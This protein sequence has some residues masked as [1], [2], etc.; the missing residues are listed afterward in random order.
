MT[1]ANGSVTPESSSA[2]RSA[3]KPS[4]LLIRSRSGASGAASAGSDWAACTASVMV[5]GLQLLYG[6]DQLA[7]GLDLGLHV[8]RDED[9]EL[10]L[11]RGD[12]IHHRQ[13]VPLEVA[14]EGGRLAQ[15]HALLVEGLD[16]LGNFVEGL[17]AVAHL[18]AFVIGSAAASAGQMRRHFVRPI[19]RNGRDTTPPSRRGLRPSVLA[20]ATKPHRVVCRH[21][22]PSRDDRNRRPGPPSAWP[23]CRAPAGRRAPPATAAGG[24]GRSAAPICRAHRPPPARSRHGSIR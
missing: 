3:I 16:Q 23:A 17:L 18:T 12:E 10:V 9:V 4:N 11:D 22:P 1:I 5:S 6:I 7:D 24:G 19:A 8:H 2:W 14:L 21:R 20:A 13:A 15:R